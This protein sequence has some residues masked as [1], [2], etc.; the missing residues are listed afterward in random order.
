MR[1]HELLN[2]LTVLERRGEAD[3]EVLGLAY[4]SREVRPGWLFVAMEGRHTDGHRYL[5]QA[6]DRGA[7]AVLHSH[8]PAS[9]RPG[10]VYLRVADPRHS[11]SPLAAA[12]HGNPSRSLRVIGVTGTDGKSTTVYLTHQ[13]LAALGEASGFLSTVHL[14]TD[15][16][17]KKNP[18]RQS[19]P[20]ASEV[21]GLLAAMAAAGKRYAVLEAT[22]HGLSPRTNRLGDVR[23]QAAVCTNIT[24]EHLEFHGTFEQYRADKANLF[25][26]LDREQ[27]GEAWQDGGG[28][29]GGWALRRGEP[30]RP[31]P[32]LPRRPDARARVYLQRPLAGGG[33]FR[34]RFPRR[35]G[36]QRAHA[37][38]G[39]RADGDPLRPAGPVQRRKPAGRRPDRAPADG[40]PLPGPGGP[41]PRSARGARAPRSPCTPG[42]LSG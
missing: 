13:L 33:P 38:L 4:D 41:L 11:L 28:G 30:G 14:Q 7:V 2:S 16:V 18:L 10:V 29:S 27:P 37:P 1:L 40:C 8:A 3:P 9:V 12:F 39:R 42:S 35:P 25:R 20:E 15:D 19:T 34:P 6:A 31:E 22:S 26:A 5:E 23:F 32:R 36:R 21:Q 17:L 24:H